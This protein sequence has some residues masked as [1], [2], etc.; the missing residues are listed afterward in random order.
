MST[1][2]LT[3]DGPVATLTLSR[4]EVLNAISRPLAADLGAALAA[5][6]ADPA[7]R[8]LIITGAGKA[9]CAGGDLA[10][11]AAIEDKTEFRRF[12]QQVGRLAATILT[13]EKPVIAMVNGVAAGA[14]FNL[15]LACDIVF[16]ARSARFAQSF[17]KVGLV[18]DMGGMYL[19][20]RLVGHHKAKELMFTADIIDAD[21][22][23]RLG[24]VNHIADD[25]DLAAATAAFAARLAAGPPVAI[26]CMKKILGRSLELDLDTVLDFEADLQ[27]VCAATADH[28]EGVAAFRAKRPPV[29][30]GK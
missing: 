1:G 23:H 24:L 11:L 2:T 16:A 4:P 9:F 14:G 17:A 3:K 7:V 13:L 29:F 10:D 8:C 15:A 5:A 25:A 19:L 22:A 28:A 27:T 12:I 6:A 20:P 21:A 18:P 30:R 26:A